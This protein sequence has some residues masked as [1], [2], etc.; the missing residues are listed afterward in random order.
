MYGVRVDFPVHNN[1]SGLQ[2]NTITM[3]MRRGHGH[4]DAFSPPV[5]APS[6]AIP[7]VVQ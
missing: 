3:T 1:I 5:V 4:K 7:K 6:H 2:L